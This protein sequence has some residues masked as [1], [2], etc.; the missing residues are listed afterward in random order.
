[1]KRS[2]KNFHVGVR[3]VETF[4]RNP[5]LRT[6]VRYWTEHKMKVQRSDLGQVEWLVSHVKSERR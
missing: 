6:V 5:S 1:M 4:C 3:T 2:Y